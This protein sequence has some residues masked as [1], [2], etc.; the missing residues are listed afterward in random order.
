MERAGK[1]QE[2]Q[3]RGGAHHT[4][5]V[6]SRSLLLDFVEFINVWDVSRFDHKVRP[7]Y[8]HHVPDDEMMEMTHKTQ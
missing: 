2:W 1:G 6:K 8:K 7:A 4:A 5:S 3:C